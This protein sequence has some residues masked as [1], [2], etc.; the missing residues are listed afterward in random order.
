MRSIDCDNEGDEKGSATR[1]TGSPPCAELVDVCD[2]AR[3]GQPDVRA[4][5]RERRRGRESECSTP[6]PSCAKRRG[7]GCR[8]RDRESKGDGKV[9]FPK[10][11]MDQAVATGLGKARDDGSNPIR[12]PQQRRV[13]HGRAHC[14]VLL[15]AWSPMH[16]SARRAATVSTRPRVEQPWLKSR[17]RKEKGSSLAADQEKPRS[18]DTSTRSGVTRFCRG[19]GRSK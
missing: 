6:R 17:G 3:G 10:R 9:L 8:R 11:Q 15:A 18:G 12:S 7:R 1:T 2:S 16:G 14:S 13:E 4:L 19:I 5:S